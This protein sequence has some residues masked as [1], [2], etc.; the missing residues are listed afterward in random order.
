M[1]SCKAVSFKMKSC[2]YI[3]FILRRV[4][5]NSHKSFTCVLKGD[6]STPLI[7]YNNR[8]LPLSQKFAYGIGHIHNDICA[9]LWF[10]YAL[11]FLQIVAETGSLLAG[12]LLFIGQAVDAVATPICGYVMAQSG[13]RKKWHLFGSVLV[14]TSFPV[15][16]TAQ[17]RLVKTPSLLLMYFSAAIIIF[18]IGWAIVQIAHLS[19]IP[20][21]S[22]YA[23]ERSQLTAHR[24]IASMVSHILVYMIAWLYLSSS[25]GITETL[26]GPKDAWRFQ[27]IAFISSGL[28][29]FCTATFHFVLKTRQADNLQKPD[30]SEKLQKQLKEKLLYFFKSSGLYKIAIIYTSSRLFMTLTLVYI[31][32][33]INEMVLSETSSLATVPL[34]CFIVSATTAMAVKNLSKCCGGYKMAYIFGSIVCII[35]CAIVQLNNIKSESTSHVYGDAI[36]FGAGSSVTMVVSLSVTANLIGNN[37]DCGSFVY[38]VVTFADKLLNGIAVVIIEH[39]KCSDMTL[40]PFY[41]RNILSFANGG[42]ALLGLFV[43]TTMPSYLFTVSNIE[44]I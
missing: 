25:Q 8:K 26:I 39:M 21:I 4:I 36:F 29:L 7:V 30:R 43:V 5:E 31:P 37:V 2:K 20:E 44:N 15:I 42:I 24:Y 11:I 13:N 27:H 32:L 9:A 6:E 34:I 1:H 41:Y 22:P 40:C 16:F 18:Q 19:L 33:Y 3:L 38:S 10:T 28:G 17:P 12:L 23:E 14:A 35:G